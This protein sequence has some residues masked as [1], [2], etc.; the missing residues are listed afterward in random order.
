MALGLGAV[1]S[2]AVVVAATELSAAEFTA[3]DSFIGLLV[4]TVS[5]STAGGAA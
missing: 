1:V 2:V 3:D 4:T 5:F